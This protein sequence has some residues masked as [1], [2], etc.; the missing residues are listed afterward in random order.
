[1][2]PERLW[3]YF[4]DSEGHLFH[5][6]VEIDD[7]KVL[8]Q[9]LKN[10]VPVGDDRGDYR[11]FCQGE[12]C[13]VTPED[14]PYVITDIQFERDKIVILFPGGYSEVLDPTTLWVGPLNVLYC[15]I[16]NGKIPARFNRRTYLELARRVVSD[17]SG[18]SFYLTIDKQSY[19][20]ET[21]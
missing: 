13:L 7:P 19:P 10:M 15:R 1:M 14:V 2:E 4:I 21:D 11:V 18:K 9:F 16:K 12:E 3:R 6:G 17:A 5:E 8:N 20:I